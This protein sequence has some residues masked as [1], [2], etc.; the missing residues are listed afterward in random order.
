MP[1]GMSLSTC[2]KGGA[3]RMESYRIATIILD[4]REALLH[5]SLCCVHRRD[6]PNGDNEKSEVYCTLCIQLKNVLL[7][8]SV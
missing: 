4:I 2:M 3:I 5:Q 7:S 6:V 8:T 1:L